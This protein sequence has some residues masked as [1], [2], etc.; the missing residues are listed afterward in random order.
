MLSS[1]SSLQVTALESHPV[2]FHMLK[3]EL[4]RQRFQKNFWSET[5][6]KGL[7]VLN[8]EALSYLEKTQ[9]T[10]DLI[11]LDPMF[12]S[13]KTTLSSKYMKCLELLQS[14][15]ETPPLERLF[16][17]SLTKAKKRVVIKRPLKAP[18]VLNVKPSLSFKGK[19]VRYDVYLTHQKDRFL[20]ESKA[21]SFL[22]RE[23][24]TFLCAS[25]KRSYN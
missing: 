16:L 22:K 24:K 7:K 13:S 18:F 25:K 17:K 6:L 23:E 11:Y 15:H 12:F 2:V 19:S 14:L 4:D 20:K 5:L 10:Y 3:E 1:K 8:K 21:L 9:E